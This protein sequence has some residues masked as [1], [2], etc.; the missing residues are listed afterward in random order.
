MKSTIK[1]SRFHLKP[2]CLRSKGRSTLK[3]V[4]R[5]D[6]FLLPVLTDISVLHPAVKSWRTTVNSQPPESCEQRD[7]MFETSRNITSKTMTTFV[8]CLCVCVW[9]GKLHKIKNSRKESAAWFMVEEEKI[10]PAL[11]LCLHSKQ[12]IFP[13]CTWY[14]AEVKMWHYSWSH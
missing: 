4:Y 14:S 12:G 3:C 11:A 9:E 13:T 7:G 10:N 8:L 1:F 2:K 6:E 5:T